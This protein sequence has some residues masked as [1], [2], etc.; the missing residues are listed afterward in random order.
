MGESARGGPR[1]R[2]LHTPGGGPVAPLYRQ[3]QQ[4]LAAQI[5][6]SD[7]PAGSLVPS[8]R[9]LC[10]R[11]GVSPIT[12]RRA[13]L[14]LTKQGL[15]YRQVG[16]GSFVA[17]PAARPDVT[18]VFAGFDA[19]R[20]RTSAGAMGELVGGVSEAAWRRDCA[21]HLQRVDRPVDGATL[22]RLAEA[23]GG[24]RHGLL[25]RVAEGVSR[26][27][28]ATL[29]ARGVPYVL[30]RRYLP[31]VPVN[32]VVPADEAGVRLAVSHLARMG[33]RRVALISAL[34]EMVLTQD[35]RRGYD[36]A[37]AAYGLDADAR[38]LELA[39]RYAPDAGYAAAA[40]LLALDPRPTAVIVDAD[41]AAGVYRAAA[42]RGLTVPRE[43]A[44][45][46]YDEVPEARSLVPSLT[47]VRTSHYETG[48]VAAEALLDMM[49][50]RAHQPQRL[51]IEPQLVVRDS[52]GAR[53]ADPARASPAAG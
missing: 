43:L 44:V 41:M 34:P 25:L 48:T 9:Q 14:E 27:D 18:L 5:R 39:E 33:H 30:I 31:D 12:A 47:C 17:D 26:D 53:A 52:C 38:L 32:C 50:G 11:Y 2:V 20:W 22:V 3:I 45:V 46:G 15:I 16:I 19:A 23:P 24:G 49:A 51:V 13:L 29:D 6:R 28:L 4:E 40:D 35:R 36:A 21:L 1:D 10:E 8:E 7:L 37:V 42:D